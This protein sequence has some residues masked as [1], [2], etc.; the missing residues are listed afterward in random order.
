MVRERSNGHRGAL[1][2]GMASS[3]VRPARRSGREGSVVAVHGCR[4]EGCAVHGAFRCLKP[5]GREVDMQ[6]TMNSE[7][8]GQSTPIDF[9]RVPGSLRAW[10]RLFEVRDLPVLR[11]SA[12][13]IEEFRANEDAVDAHMLSE[14]LS[15]DPLSVLKILGRVAE[16]R[17]GRDETDAE[18]LTESLVMMGITPFFRHFGPQRAAEDHLAL[19]PGATEGFRKVL[20]RSHRAARFAL[21]F[22]VQR[23]DH[24]AAVIH[25]A[26]LLHDFVELLMWL[27][28][29]AL[30]TEVSRRQSIDPSLRSAV[31]QADVFNIVLAELQHALMLKWRL[32]RLLVEIA[33]DQRGS[34]SAQ[35]RSVVLA[36]RLARHTALDW[37]NPAIDDDVEEIARLL[38]MG[39]DPTIALLHEI[40]MP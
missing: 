20:A 6:V 10:T 9:E 13:A 33:D 15:Q 39:I 29:P 37:R 7:P 21:A 25:E 17:R 26:A 31:A 30:A 11:A 14:A 38:N 3:D 5:D 22:A 35:S 1:Q 34:A 23:M 4:N 12:L 28:A 36:I 24:D 40:D 18:T 27:H 16:L 19:Y 8:A 32:P 2:P